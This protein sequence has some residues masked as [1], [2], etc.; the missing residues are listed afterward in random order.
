MSDADIKKERIY[1]KLQL[2]KKLFNKSCERI[3]TCLS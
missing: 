2:Q 3:R 1:E